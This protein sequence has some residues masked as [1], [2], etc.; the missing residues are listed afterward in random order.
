MIGFR[1]LLTAAAAALAF[2]AGPA[3]A[4]D[5]DVVA[6]GA[7]AIMPMTDTMCQAIAGFE[8]EVY[9]SF[10]LDKSG[11][12]R[13]VLVS[14]NWTLEAGQRVTGTVSNDGW[15]TS[16]PIEFSAARLG[17]GAWMIHTATDK[18]FGTALVGTRQVAFRVP[19]V[20][21]DYRFDVPEAQE[22]VTA[23]QTCN[24]KR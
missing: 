22:L 10:G 11:A 14:P 20:K 2:A 7:W 15:R 19:A 13:L 6:V 12:G 18:A 5:E 4:Q 3:L 24:S 1:H 21:L 9:L 17:N 8:D 16:R 23:I